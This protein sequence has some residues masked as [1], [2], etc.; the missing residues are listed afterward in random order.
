MK[1]GQTDL[2]PLPPSPGKTTFKNP[3]LISVKWSSPNFIPVITEFL[4]SLKL[5]ESLSFLWFQW[6]KKIKLTYLNSLN[7]RSK[8]WRPSFTDFLKRIL[9]SVATTAQLS[10]ENKQKENR[11]FKCDLC[12]A[13]KL[14]LL[15]SSH[16]FG[17]KCKQKTNW[18]QSAIKKNSSQ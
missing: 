9:A 3:S 15:N 16:E 2:P 10:L 7:I 5:S 1:R 4:S 14:K 6:G 11:A 17:P 8:I 12:L 13:V 18:R